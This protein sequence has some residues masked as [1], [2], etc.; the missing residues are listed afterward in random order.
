MHP[1]DH[2]ANYK[3]SKDGEIKNKVTHHVSAVIH[4]RHVRNFHFQNDY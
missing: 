3:S 1:K 4:I 2:P